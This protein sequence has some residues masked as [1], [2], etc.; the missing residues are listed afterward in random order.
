MIGLSLLLST[1]L[2]GGFCDPPRENRPVVWWWWN[3]D[4]SQVPRAA[5]TRDLEGLKRVGVSGFHIYGGSV[6]GK[7]W[8][9]KAKWAFHEANRLGLDGYVMIGAAGCGHRATPHR[10]APKD[11][12]FTS[13]RA[14]ADVTFESPCRRRA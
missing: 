13:V 8:T 10:F 3:D 6:T 2:V 1:T 7:G 4:M 12:V 5:I 11:I 14:E 9:E